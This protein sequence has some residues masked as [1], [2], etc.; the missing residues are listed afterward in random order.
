MK[1]S[2]YN[3]LFTSVHVSACSYEY[4]LTLAT[5]SSHDYAPTENL[6]L[7]AVYCHPAALCP[8]YTLPTSYSAVFWCHLVWVVKCMGIINNVNIDA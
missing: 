5:H 7:I 2:K 1:T 4:N 3:N 8:P 6:L